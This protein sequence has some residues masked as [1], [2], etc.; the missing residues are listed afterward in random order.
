MSESA[1]TES[2]G[3]LVAELEQAHG[4]L[5]DEEIAAAQSEWP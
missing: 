5:T 3:D 2:L 4:P 1:S